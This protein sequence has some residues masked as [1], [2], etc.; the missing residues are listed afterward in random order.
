VRARA[1]AHARRS[2]DRAH[3]FD[4]LPRPT[5]RSHA[6]FAEKPA[7]L[8]AGGSALGVA[9]ATRMVYMVIE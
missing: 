3:D 9:A 8:D 2:L 6:P 5:L 4:Y 1:C 7:R